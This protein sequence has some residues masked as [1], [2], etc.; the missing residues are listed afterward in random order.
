MVHRKFRRPCLSF[1]GFF[2][3]VV[4][5]PAGA[6]DDLL[7]VPRDA[8]VF[9]WTVAELLANDTG[10]EGSSVFLLSQPTHGELVELSDE[11]FEYSPGPN[12]GSLGMDIF[13]YQYPVG[14]EL[15]SA[16][17]YLLADLRDTML[18]RES[19][20]DGSLTPHL[21]QTVGFGDLLNLILEDPITRDWAIEVDYQTAR[22]AY[23]QTELSYRHGETS[24]GGNVDMDIDPGG[25]GVLTLPFGREFHLVSGLANSSKIIELVLLSDASGA[26]QLVARSR[27]S[28]LAGSLMAETQA[29]EISDDPHRVALNWWSATAVGARDGGLILVV[30]GRLAGTAMG[31]DNYGLIPKTLRFGAI[32]PP[33][34]ANGPSRFDDLEI[35]TSRPPRFPPLFA[36]GF[37]SDDLKI[38]S[39]T[40]GGFPDLVA[41]TEARFHGDLGLEVTLMP[42]TPAYLI[43]DSPHREHH[44]RARFNLRLDKSLLALPETDPLELF[45]AND[46]ILG[47]WPF[48]M[49]LRQRSG[50]FELRAAVASSLGSTANLGGWIQLPSE[51]PGA[52]V[53]VSLEIQWWAAPAGTTHGGARLW[54]DGVLGGRKA[55]G[56]ANGH[57]RID[58]IALGAIV[59]PTSSMGVLHLDDF[60]SWR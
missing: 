52:T 30:D 59:V 36:D 7:I 5:L 16:A 6:E 34:G 37:E 4:S 28:G 14:G 17:V 41:T 10:V 9:R 35:W 53:E 47:D 39:R 27:R 43:D 55:L 11:T 46:Q 15:R 26:L 32:N 31:I 33:L 50:N 3:L 38:W 18:V 54:I 13:R 40:V 29:V 49:L 12:F 42:G 1:V 44:Y 19:V 8:G 23:L 57:Q 2:F 25:D 60:E 45:Q 51:H 21:W 24:A 58:E 56:L 48:K 22:V 20:E